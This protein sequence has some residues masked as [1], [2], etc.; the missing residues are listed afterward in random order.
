M[1]FVLDNLKPIL[2]PPAKKTLQILEYCSSPLVKR[3]PVE[4][5]PEWLGKLH[6]INVPK[7][8]KPHNKPSPFGGSN[9]KIIFQLIRD[10]QKLTGDV[11]ECGVFQ[12]A[13]VASIGLYLQQSGTDKKAYG[14]DSF[15][16]F[17]ESIK[18]D[19]ELGG[20]DAW[21]KSVGGFNDTSYEKVRHKLD[22]LG[23]KDRV[24]L[25]KGYFENTLEKYSEKKFSFVHL[26][27][28]TYGSYKTCLEFF[29]PRVVSGGIILLDEYNDPPWPGCNKAVDEFL[30]GKPEK[31][32]EL[33][34]DNYLKYGF[35]KI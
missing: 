4:S 26:D 2:A 10:T 5:C 17:D 30:T 9:I 18:F 1:S 20:D 34:S 6:G 21:N 15:E 32:I 29:Y 28:D 24:T 14:F 35:K 23:L 12:G 3:L 27:C 25:V 7:R 13:S 31:L 19:L 16:G 8:V 11:A 33:E 22:I